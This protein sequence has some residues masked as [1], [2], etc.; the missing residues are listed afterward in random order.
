[1]NVIASGKCSRRECAR[2]LARFCWFEGRQSIYVEC[3]WCK[4][5]KP[6]DLRM[7][8]AACWCGKLLFHTES[9]EGREV[10]SITCPDC[11]DK[12]TVDLEG[13]MTLFGTDPEKKTGVTPHVSEPRLTQ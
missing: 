2:L 5:E 4:L 1:M 8:G 6:F 7:R 12:M 9:P 13:L 11:G 3:P 10:I